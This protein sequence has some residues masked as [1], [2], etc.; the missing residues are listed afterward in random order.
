MP[1]IFPTYFPLYINTDRPYDLYNL[2]FIFQTQVQIVFTNLYDIYA[3]GISLFCKTLNRMIQNC[4]FG[5]RTTC[6]Y[7]Y[8]KIVVHFDLIFQK[9]IWREERQCAMNFDHVYEWSKYFEIVSVNSLKPVYNVCEP[10]FSG[11]LEIYTV[12]S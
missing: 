2:S 1:R 9:T 7:P 12:L 11:L 3:Y 8:L 6:R 10:F 4:K 5:E